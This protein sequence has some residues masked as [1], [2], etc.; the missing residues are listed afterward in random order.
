MGEGV[1]HAFYH[2]QVFL[3][4]LCILLADEF[5]YLRVVHIVKAQRFRNMR[6]VGLVQVESRL[7]DVV[8]AFE[9][10]SAIDRPTQ[11]AHMNTQLLLHL[12]Q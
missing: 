9:A 11:R 3:Q 7:E 1:I 6:L 8:H 4:F 2:L 10:L 12:I 5:G